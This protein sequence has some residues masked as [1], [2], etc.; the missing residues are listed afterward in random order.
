VPKHALRAYVICRR[1]LLTE[2]DRQQFSHE[3]ANVPEPAQIYNPPPSAFK[4]P[5]TNDEALLIGHFAALW[6]QIDFFLGSC[7]ASFLRTD[8]GAT[9]VLME[10]MTTGPRLNLFYRLARQKITDEAVLKQA[11]DFNAALSPLIEKRNQIVHGMW[12]TWIAPTHSTDNQ[13]ASLHS[14]YPYPLKIKEIPPLIERVADQT[15]AIVAIYQHLSGFHWTRNDANPPI[16]LMGVGAPTRPP[17]ELLGR[18]GERPS[19]KQ[20]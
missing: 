1:L 10:S 11:K 3:R 17:Q 19:N 9:Q 2:V 5:F 20:I 12:G 15:F 6:G 7:I 4:I 8:L 14:K 18:H 13:T 16:F